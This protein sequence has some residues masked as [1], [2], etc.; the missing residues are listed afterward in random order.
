MEFDSR[1]YAIDNETSVIEVYIL[2]D[3]PDVYEPSK[4]FPFIVDVTQVDGTA[5][6]KSLYRSTY[7]S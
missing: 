2:V 5:I 6:S 1:S 7:S 4:M 3:Y